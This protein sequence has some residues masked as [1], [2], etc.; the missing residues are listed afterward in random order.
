MLMMNIKEL[1]DFCQL[2]NKSIVVNKGMVTG[3][4]S[5]DYGVYN[6]TRNAE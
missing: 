5:N 3:I 1:D 4:T 2:N 6:C